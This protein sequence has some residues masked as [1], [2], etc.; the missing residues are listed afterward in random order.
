M[1]TIGE[2]TFGKARTLGVEWVHVLPGVERQFRGNEFVPILALGFKRKMIFKFVNLGGDM[3][4]N[5]IY[6]CVIT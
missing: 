6:E 3:L 2:G 4:V 1:K 5:C